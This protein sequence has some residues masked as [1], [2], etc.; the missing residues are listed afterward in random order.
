MLEALTDAAKVVE[1]SQLRDVGLVTELGLEDTSLELAVALE[2]PGA[3]SHL[4][5]GCEFPASKE[6]PSSKS[7]RPLCSFLPFLG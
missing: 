2:E 5:I 4:T 7:A 1:I 3:S 6:G